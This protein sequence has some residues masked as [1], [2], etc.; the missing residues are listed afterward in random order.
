MLNALNAIWSFMQGMILIII[1]VLLYQ[2]VKQQG[3]LLLRLDQVDRALGIGGPDGVQVNGLEVGTP[4]SDFHLPDL[5]GQTVSLEDFRGKQVLLVHW[6]P[7]CG[8]CESIAPDLARLHPELIDR[9]AHLI[10]VTRDEAKANRDLAEEHGMECPILLMG[11][12]DPLASV[13][14]RDQG[15][16]VA[17]LLDQEGR[18]ARPLA[19]GG[20]AILTIGREIAGER[21]P[22]KRLPGE[23]PLS[24]SRLIRDG[25]KAGTP[26]PPFCL[27]NLDGLMVQLADYLG[28]RVL[29]IFTDPHCGP[30]EELSPRLARRQQDCQEAGVEVIMVAR[31][32]VEENRV[33]AEL[34]GFEFPIVIQERWKLSQ[35]Y[36][37]FA[38][39]VAFLIGEDG[40]ILRNVARGV[41]EILALI[42]Q[43]LVA[44][45]PLDVRSVRG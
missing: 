37:I 31:G 3:R 5:H 45:E 27:P 9:G 22:R 33:K 36:G 10:L 13:A 17:Y 18:V 19:V 4:I 42:P 1:C 30:C 41:D 43:G 2:I 35:E 29:L 11:V 28:R 40:V 8:F 14:F 16:P 15:T 26:A 38:V 6:G 44:R 32:Q 7:V 23:R 12:D 21:I 25:L 39:P 34:H 24:E 20:E